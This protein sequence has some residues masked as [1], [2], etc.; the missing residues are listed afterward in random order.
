[1]PFFALIA[2][3]ILVAIAI[4]LRAPRPNPAAKAGDIVDRKRPIVIAEMPAEPRPSDSI[5]PPPR[6]A[7]GRRPRMA[8][9]LVVDFIPLGPLAPA[10]LSGS[11]QIV[12]VRIDNTPAH[13]VLGEDGIAQG[14]LWRSR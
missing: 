9:Q 3:A 5:A 8:R 11:F 10:E 1:D 14:I 6:R 2:A 7:A 4:S 12:P 13:L